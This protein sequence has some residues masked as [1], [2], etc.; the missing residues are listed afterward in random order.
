MTSE[1]LYLALKGRFRVMVIV[2]V[3]IVV[4]IFIGSLLWPKSYKAIT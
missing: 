4:P 2:F 3:S 1:H